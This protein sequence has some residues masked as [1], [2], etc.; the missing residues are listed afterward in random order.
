MDSLLPAMLLYLVL[1]TFAFA[2]IDWQLRRRRLGGFVPS[3]W[4]CP[5]CGVQNEAP[6]TVCGS[7]GAAISVDPFIPGAG[8]GTKGSWRC[9]RCGSWNGAVR[10]SCWSCSYQPPGE[11]GARRRIV[12]TP[13]QWT[14]R[15]MPPSTWITFPVR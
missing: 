9:E 3:G 5:H 11:I 12:G 6:R 14:P 8:P 1:A 15:N 10:R 13:G 2:S 4:A 7:C